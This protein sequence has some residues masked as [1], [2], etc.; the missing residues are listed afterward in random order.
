MDRN[1]MTKGAVLTELAKRGITRVEVEYSG[2]NDEG[3]VD[4]ITFYKGE[5]VVEVPEPR[6]A[7]GFVHDPKTGKW[8][9][10]TKGFTPEELK[11][12]EFF[13]GLEAPVYAKYYSFAGEFY[14][15]G[16]VIWDVGAGTCKMQGYE[17]EPQGR[18][19]DEDY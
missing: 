8:V 9:Q 2:G 6:R 12:G 14:A 13:E 10:E 4:D 17:E 18:N 1:A 16:K 5:D 11:E 3:G 19:F 15:N 7:N